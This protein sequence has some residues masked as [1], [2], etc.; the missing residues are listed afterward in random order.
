MLQFKI[1]KLN[2]QIDFMFVAIVT[3]FLLVDQ[4]GISAI[5]LLACFI[6]ELGHIVMFIAVGYT[7]Q[8]L[9]FELTGIRLTKPIQE[10]SRGKE[11]LVQLAGSGTNLAIFFLLVSTIESVSF[12]SIFGVTHLVLGVFNLLPLKSFDGGKVLSIIASYFMSENATQIVCTI[13]DFICILF[14]LTACIFMI[15][16]S[17]SSFSLVMVTIYLMIS[18]IVKLTKR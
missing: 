10:L 13:T 12:Y 17:N 8:K 4:T 1:G 16:T 6:H 11:L 9:T 18:S 14:L 7:P 3:I 5:A 15:V 2:V